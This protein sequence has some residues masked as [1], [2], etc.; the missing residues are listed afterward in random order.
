MSTWPR[1]GK[2]INWGLLVVSLLVVGGM[3]LLITGS[4]T[5]SEGLKGIL[6]DHNNPYYHFSEATVA[7]EVT[8]GTILL[9]LGVAC[10]VAFVM[11]L[12]VRRSFLFPPEKQVHLE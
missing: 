1:Y 5:L 3:A 9:I 7:Q 12:L 8:Y 10:F 4:W 2:P 11:L 6:V